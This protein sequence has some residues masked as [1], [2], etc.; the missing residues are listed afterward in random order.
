MLD[1]RYFRNKAFST[2][3]GG[4][5]LV[6]LGMY[7]T[8]FLVIQYLQLILGYSALSTAVRILPMTP[9]MMVV[10]PLTPRLSARFG[11]NRTVAVGM[12]FIAAGF[13][14]LA[15]LTPHSSYAYVLLSFIPLISGIALTMSPMTSAIMSAVPE[16]RAG[17]G[18]AMNDATR[19]LGAALGVAV[20]GSI[21]A[22]RY[23]SSLDGTISAL[24]AGA[25]ESARSSLAGALQVA[26]RLPASA[27][28]LLTTASQH[29]FVDGI[30]VA[31][32][33][34]LVLALIAA[35]VVHRYLPAVT[36]HGVTADSEAVETDAEP[37]NDE[38]EPA[39][40]LTA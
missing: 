28:R 30:R 19:E 13:L 38:L 2:G 29:A 27:G 32:I 3:T 36:T 24:P 25:R 39:S 17:A 22:S 1:M 14:F 5:I 18:S 10:A 20:L 26:S 40:S 4:M 6:F 23:T 15:G 31:S 7:G 34:G 37:V 9:I 16:R 35:V 11:A 21:A 8:M 33:A 12:L